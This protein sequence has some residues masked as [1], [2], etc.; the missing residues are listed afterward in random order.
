MARLLLF[1]IV[2]FLY[3]CAFDNA[4]R[5][6][7][8]IAAYQVRAKQIKLGDSKETVLNLLEPTQVELNPRECKSPEAF[9]QDQDTFEI[10]FF[11]SGRQPDGLT[12]DDE[13]TPYVFKNGVLT[14]I[15]WTVLGGPKTVGKTVPQTNVTVGGGGTAPKAMTTCTRN[16]PFLHCF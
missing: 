5:I 2:L 1:A 12:T 16:G 7:D 6:D 13:F 10:H 3:G 8:A 14:A 15:G 4:V 11:R 9:Q